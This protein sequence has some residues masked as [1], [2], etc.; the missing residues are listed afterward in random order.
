MRGSRWHGRGA[1]RT[2]VSLD[3]RTG[4]ELLRTHTEAHPHSSVAV[5]VQRK[6]VFV[7]DN[8]G[9]LYALDAQTGSYEWRTKLLEDGKTAIKTTPSVL[10]RRHR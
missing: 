9:Y 7:G 2:F 8:L 4:E 3:A 6:R 5:D 1:L 10:A